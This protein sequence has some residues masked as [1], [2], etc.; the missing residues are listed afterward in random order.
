MHSLMSNIDK[1]NPDTVIITGDF[2]A[3]SP[4]FW[5]NELTETS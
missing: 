4:L 3:R 2:N 5:E 1:E